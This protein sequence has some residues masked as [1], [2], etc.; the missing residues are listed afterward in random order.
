MRARLVGALKPEALL[1][2]LAALEL[3]AEH[4]GVAPHSDR[5]Q[6]IAR[7]TDSLDGSMVGVV[8]VFALLL[9]PDLLCRVAFS[10]WRPAP[11][12]SRRATCYEALGGGN[13][14]ARRGGD[15][16]MSIVVLLDDGDIETKHR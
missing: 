8:A 14:Y 6:P 3:E 1:C 13:T 10:Q 15:D 12:R 2:P 9:L 4:A 16:E 5:R 11:S 7:D